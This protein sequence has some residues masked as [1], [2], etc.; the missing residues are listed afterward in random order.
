MMT[1][2]VRTATNAHNSFYVFFL[3]LDILYGYY[4]HI[5]PGLTV[6]FLIFENLFFFSFLLAKHGQVHVQFCKDP[7]MYRLSL[8]KKKR[9]NKFV[10]I[11]FKK[12]THKSSQ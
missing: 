4:S 6:E 7:I 1:L 3:P 12:L 11:F 2:Y 9:E 10:P 5:W 8:K